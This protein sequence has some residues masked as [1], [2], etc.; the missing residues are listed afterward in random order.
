MP[1]TPRKSPREA[2]EQRLRAEANGAVFA[3]ARGT[4]FE[5]GR[6]DEVEEYVR[7]GLEKFDQEQQER[8]QI[9]NP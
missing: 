2:E 5:D 6:R 9:P 4:F 3:P 8:N 7:K 1:T